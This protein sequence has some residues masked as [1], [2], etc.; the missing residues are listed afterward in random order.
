MA[1]KSGKKSFLDYFRVDSEDDYEEEYD[2]MEED[3]FDDEEEE[4]YV[5]PKKVKKL[6]EKKTTSLDNMYSEPDYDN[7]DSAYTGTGFGQASTY[8]TYSKPASSF[9]QSQT[10]FGNRKYNRFTREDMQMNN[11]V[12]E[13]NVVSFDKRQNYKPNSEVYVIKPLEFDDAQTVSDFLKA[14]KTIVINMEGVQIDPAQRIIDFI[15]GA[16]YGLG[17]DLKAI[18]A[19]IFIA[20]PHNIEVS[21]DLRDEILNESTLSPQLGKY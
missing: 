5:K 12:K 17:G 6:K 13:Q 11:E 20:A 21:G 18:S 8:N 14:G 3:L 2:G 9:Q 16:C 19:N 4:V 10:S 7:F 1:K 15:G